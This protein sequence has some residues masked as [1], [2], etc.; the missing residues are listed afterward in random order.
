MDIL[1]A[2]ILEGPVNKTL[3]ELIIMSTRLGLRLIALKDLAE[4]DN[5]EARIVSFVTHFIKGRVKLI[6]SDFDHLNL[7]KYEVA[8]ELSEVFAILRVVNK[9]AYVW[10]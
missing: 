1:L 6:Q 10:S 5:I 2:P 3:G 8:R 9:K 7:G 4:S